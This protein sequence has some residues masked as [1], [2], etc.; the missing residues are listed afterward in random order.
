MSTPSRPCALPVLLLLLLSLVV[1]ACASAAAPPT[2][3]ASPTPTA[4]AP[5]GSVTTDPGSGQPGNPG[6]VVDPGQPQLVIPKPGQLDVHPVAI[7]EMEVRVEGRHAV[8]NARW[9][10][11]V[12]PCYVLDSVAWKRDGTTI[13]V[14]IREGHG[15]ADIVCIDIATFRATVV[16]L[17]ELEPGDYTVIAG[18][19]N[20]APVA[21]TIG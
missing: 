10:S 21:F 16:D 1:S 6:G 3:D 9:W 4:P 15:P 11:G 20:A 8:L 12:E 5:G 2:A 14:S 17:G 19:G 18:D 13:T 7:E